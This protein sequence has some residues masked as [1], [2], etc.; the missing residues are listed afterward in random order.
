MARKGESTNR[1]SFSSFALGVGLSTVSFPARDIVF[2]LMDM[3]FPMN[4]GKSER[5]DKHFLLLDI[6]AM[7]YHYNTS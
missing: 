7:Y 2:R 6:F 3:Y 1:M 4:E 5:T